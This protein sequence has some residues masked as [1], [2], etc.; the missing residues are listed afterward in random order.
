[1]IRIQPKTGASVM[2]IEAKKGWLKVIVG[3][4]IHSSLKFTPKTD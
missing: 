4:P 1:M 2:T 3:S